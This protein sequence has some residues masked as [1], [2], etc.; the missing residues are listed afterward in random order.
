MCGRVVVASRMLCIFL[1]DSIRAR[2]SNHPTAR[3]PGPGVADDHKQ[4]TCT[5]LRSSG[6]RCKEAASRQAE[7]AAAGAGHVPRV[8]GMH[9]SARVFLCVG[10]V[11]LFGPS[12]GPPFSPPSPRRSGQREPIPLGPW[13]L[14]TADGSQWRLIAAFVSSAENL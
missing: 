10:I 6:V 9:Y 3:A 4:L 13:A 14:G 5:R 2:D 8:R 11:S 12:R 1:G 7:A